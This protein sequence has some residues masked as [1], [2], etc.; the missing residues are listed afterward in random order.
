MKIK[1]R[2]ILLFDSLFQP[3]TEWL[4]FE[5]TLK[6]I[7][8]LIPPKASKDIIKMARKASKCLPKHLRGAFLYNVTESIESGKSPES[9]IEYWIDDYLRGDQ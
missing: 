3:T 2:A 9:A 4:A 1:T 8:S 7:E 5:S 6:D